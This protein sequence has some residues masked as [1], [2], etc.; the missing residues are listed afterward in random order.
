MLYLFIYVALAGL[1]FAAG[2]KAPADRGG[3]LVAL[4]LLS[5]FVAFRFEVG[6]DWYGYSNQFNLAGLQLEYSLPSTGR[7]PLWWLLLKSQQKLGLPYYWMNIV[8]AGVLFLGLH[9][10]ARRQP[11]RLHFL[12]F[13][14]PVLIINVGITQVRQGL[15]VGII[16]F[17]FI[18]FQQKRPILFGGLVLLA[19]G[20]HSSALA[21]LLLT[22]LMPGRLSLRNVL[23]ASL[24]ALP[25]LYLL[26]TS[27]VA[28]VA[29]D[30]YI[31][32]DVD[33]AGAL[34]RIAL[35][36]FASVGFLLFLRL[37]WEERF[38]ED[39][40]LIYLGS[41]LMLIPLPLALQS[42]VIGDRFA[43]YLIPLQAMMFARVRYLIR[44][45]EIVTLGIHLILGSFLGVWIILSSHF[46][47]CYLPYRTWL[48]GAPVSENYLY[49]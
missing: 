11:D 30:R 40:K 12:A 18:A 34:F 26:V 32:R 48:F 27:D 28:E 46:N 36:A 17:A 42:S 6:C 9:A 45:G 2:G 21:F 7:E 10:L 29:V 44:S 35:L 5:V 47:Q 4:I 31:V 33:A 49:G 22:P 8:P 37:I 43:Y 39:Y 20:F 15:A 3:Y 38:P 24:L 16:C 23:L 14:F 13:C 1:A 25:G 41:L 19:S